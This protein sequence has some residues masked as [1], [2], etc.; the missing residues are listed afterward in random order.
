MPHSQYPA[1][2]RH[3]PA[4]VWPLL[5]VALAL[6]GLAPL[7]FPP[8]ADA[9]S[10]NLAWDPDPDPTTTYTIYYGTSSGNYPFSQQA[11]TQTTCTVTGLQE[12]Q[13]YFFAAK[14]CKGELCSGFSAEISYTVPAA[15]QPPTASVSANK[16]S[17]K[18]PLAVNFTGSGTDPDGTIA[19]YSWS[20]GDGTTSTQQNPSKTYNTQG[21]YTAILTVTDN[22]GATGTAQL[23]VSVQ[24]PNQSPTANASANPTSGTAP[25]TVNFTGSGTDPDG[26]IAGYSWAFG[27][28]TTSTQQNPTHQY[29]A[30][31]AYT[32]VLTVTDND[33]A[34]KTATLNIAVSSA[35]LEEAAKKLIAGTGPYTSKG[36][37]IAFF[38]EDHLYKLLLQVVWPE[39]VAANGEVRVATGD[40]DGDGRHEIVVG[41]G[42]VPKNSSLPGGKFLVLKHDYSP[43]VWGRVSWPDYNAANGETWPACCDLDGDGEAEVLV[44]LGPQGA[45]RVEV[46]KYSHGELNHQAWITV[47][48]ADYNTA[49]GETRPSCA[50]LDGDGK[51]EI[52]IGLGPVQGSSSMPGGR[53]QVL[54]H[55]F[56]PLAWGVVDWPDYASSNGET[57]P[58]AGDVDGDGKAEIVVGLGSG[59]GGKTEVLEYSS[60][61]VTHAAWM[62]VNWDDYSALFGET[63]PA[64][65]DVDKD[66]IGEIAVGLGKGGGGW[67]EL[68]DDS[69]SAHASLFSTQVLWDEYNDANGETWPAFMPLS[70]GPLISDVSLSPNPTQGE[71]TV[72]LSASADAPSGEPQTI[73]EAEWWLDRWT[74]PG[75]PMQA[76]DGALDSGSEGLRATIDVSPWTPGDYTI[77]VRAREA[78][79][80][81]GEPASAV[82]K[83]MVPTDQVTITLVQYSKGKLTINAT[84]SS[85][86]GTVTLSAEGLGALKYNKKR[87]VYQAKLKGVKTKPSSVTVVS[88]GGGRDTK[89][90]P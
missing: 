67:I 83:V 19:G 73:V 17:G 15:N 38:G 12:G 22:K 29:T 33:G 5:L 75:Y 13:T 85:Q 20:F 63:R 35:A 26:T 89:A 34:S 32:V 25:L 78:G 6:S 58:A 43:M 79:G 54:D 31:G 88:T 80:T 1:P 44:G 82:L 57:W 28:G 30:Q 2:H 46:F 40:I 8:A 72:L 56:T 14:A 76:E 18:A 10:V 24:P 60:G 87:K 4:K 61:G 69:S 7:P 37:A 39:Y 27:D 23:Q 42:P 55:D 16:T 62:T 70:L 3:G 65:G 50:D 45:G 64:V 52:V 71:G 81:W 77:F 84:C 48:W 36:G 68:F 49:G 90:V 53:F 21:T 86:P 47:D 74:G 66:G 9:A 51:D 41:F 59:G 11:G